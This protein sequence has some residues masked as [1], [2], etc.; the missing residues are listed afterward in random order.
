MPLKK[1]ILG[2][3]LCAGFGAVNAQSWGGIGAL[4]GIGEALQRQ[5]EQDAAYERQK[6]LFLLEMR[7]RERQQIEAE[8]RAERAEAERAKREAQ[9][10]AVRA[11]AARAR[12]AAEAEAQRLAAENAARAKKAEEEQIAAD[13]QEQRRLNRDSP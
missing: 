6:E 3:C 13:R 11:A 7:E 4:Q 12:W 2:L 5:A 9:A 1:T 10:E 8:R